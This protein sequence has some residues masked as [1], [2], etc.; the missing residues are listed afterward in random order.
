MGAWPGPSW[1]SPAG[2][3]PATPPAST[4]GRAKSSL[5][6]TASITGP[7]RNDCPKDGTIEV[8]R[9]ICSIRNDVA[10]PGVVMR[11]ALMIL[12]GLALSAGPALSET[13]E[14]TVKANTRSAI[15]GF[16][17]Y[18][19]D[20]CYPSAIPDVKVRQAPAN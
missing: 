17:G 11:R 20:T 15:G 7:D 12:A 19:V 2:S 13:V 16:L 4:S 10:E 8:V 9:K 5:S 14:R 18:E 3:R 1:P 6:R